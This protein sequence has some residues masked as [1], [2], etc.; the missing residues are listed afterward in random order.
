MPWHDY[1]K[2]IV[3]TK[4]IAKAKRASQ[5]TWKHVIKKFYNNI[6]NNLNDI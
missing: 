6:V 1:E 2:N 4:T 3:D 5:L